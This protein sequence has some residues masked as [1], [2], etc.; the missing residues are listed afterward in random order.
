[1]THSLRKLLAWHYQ[2]PPEWTCELEEWILCFSTVFSFGI[3]GKSLDTWGGTLLIIGCLWVELNRRPGGHIICLWDHIMHG[4]LWL[5]GF[6]WENLKLRTSL[7]ITGW[8]LTLQNFVT[9]QKVFENFAPDN[10]T[11]FVSASHSPIN[12]GILVFFL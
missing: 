10:V 5:W 7:N 9:G 12:L 1:M 4:W 11:Q 6:L 8:L 3:C 2:H